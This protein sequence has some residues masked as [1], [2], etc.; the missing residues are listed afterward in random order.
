MR[1]GRKAGSV[2]ASY[3]AVTSPQKQDFLLLQG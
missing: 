3:E 1:P 2:E